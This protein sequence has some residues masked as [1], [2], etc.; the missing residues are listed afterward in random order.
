MVDQNDDDKRKRAILSRIQR[1]IWSHA[2]TVRISEIVGDSEH[3]WNTATGILIRLQQRLL[4]ITAWHVVKRFVEI[5]ERGGLPVLIL[6]NHPIA[7]PRSIYLDS[8]N[9][10]V[11]LEVSDSDE[12]ATMAT[13]YQ[14]SRQWPPPRV[15]RED[16]VFICGFPALSR[17]DED[18]ILH[19][20]LSFFGSVES[21]SEYQF[22]VQIDPDNVID[23]GRAPFPAR[24]ADLGGM[25][26]SPAFAIYSD[27][28]QLV[29]I[30][31]QSATTAPVWLI[32]SLA[33]LPIDLATHPSES[34]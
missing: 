34:I 28:M 23:A 6:G 14:P 21:V 15:S 4:A 31:S 3:S 13:P 19:G 9:D 29:G 12:Q 5:R 10:L 8:Y 24:D 30:F 20:D 22:V 16:A 32:R 18:E 2:L 33:H 26:G 1:R 27:N 17:R 25:S 11:V 7:E